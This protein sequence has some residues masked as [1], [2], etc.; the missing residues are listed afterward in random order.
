MPRTKKIEIPLPEGLILGSRVRYYT[1]QGW[2]TGLLDKWENGRAGI[3]PIGGYRSGLKRHVSVAEA[4]VEPI[5]EVKGS[6]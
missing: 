6:S 1:E 2:K 4:N 3:L 5:A